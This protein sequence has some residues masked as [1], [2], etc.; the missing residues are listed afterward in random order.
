MGQP[1][2][3]LPWAGVTMLEHVVS[4]LAPVCD[5]IVVVGHVGQTLSLPAAARRVDDPDALDDQGPLV[6]AAS[7]LASVD[8][9]ACVY[10]AAVDKP[11]IRA[12][13]VAF[14]FDQLE[15]VEAAAPRDPSNNRVHPL[16]AAVRAGPTHDAAN[17]L[18][19]AG[20]RALK[21]VFDKL[22]MRW[23]DV[24]TLPDPMVLHDCNTPEQYE[25][26]RR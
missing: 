18:I 12:E 7:G 10:L 5:E 19:E 21:R 26:L 25:R 11:H 13:H 9:S 2:A 3:L 14:M 24:D 6:G 22:H 8:P 16:A 15:G 20:E 23:I 4:Q 1:K 17:V